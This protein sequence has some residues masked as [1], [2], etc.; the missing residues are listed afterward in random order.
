VY[1]LGI[2]LGGYSMPDGLPN[3]RFH[4]NHN[5]ERITVALELYRL[6][7]IKRILISTGA[8]TLDR[9]G[10]NEA[11]HTAAFLQRLGIPD[12]AIIIEDR[13]RNTYENAL[14]TA[15]LLSSKGLYG[16]SSLLITSPFHMRRSMACFRKQGLNPTPFPAGVLALSGDFTSYHKFLPHPI[17]YYRWEALSKEIVGMAMYKLQGYI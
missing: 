16:Q 12:T 11:H 10:P 7:K 15:E 8:L 2:V 6:G 4:P 1:E 3:D 17:S 14:F 13:S 9:Q 5:A